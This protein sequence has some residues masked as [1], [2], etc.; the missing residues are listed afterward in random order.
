[1]LKRHKFETINELLR[2]LAVYKAGR[3]GIPLYAYLEITNRCNFRCVHCYC[4]LSSKRKEMTYSEVCLVLDQLADIGS[5]FLYIS[6]GEP[7]IRPDFWKILE[8]ARKKEFAIILNTN[9]SMITRDVAQRLADLIIFKVDMSIYGMSEYSYKTVTR[10]SGIF[11][12]IVRGLELLKEK[13]IRVFVKIVLMRDNFYQL[14]AFEKFLKKMGIEYK[15]NWVL[16]PRLDR[17]RSP[18]IHNLTKSQMEKFLR[19]HPEHHKPLWNSKPS[20]SVIMCGHASVPSFVC[21]NAYGEVMPCLLL[22][23][24]A[25]KHANIRERL[26]VE[27][28]KKDPLFLR[29][30]SFRWQ[31]MPQCLNCKALLYCAPCPADFVLAKGELTDTVPKTMCRRA[32]IRKRIH[33]EVKYDTTT[34]KISGKCQ[35]E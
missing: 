11:K 16:H 22:T 6:G 14:E 8:Y 18:L 1:M 24:L 19:S 7:F 5:L 32:W 12:K 33:E 15:I 13:G 23:T 9:G 27:I 35:I 17:C 10:V 2:Y 31:N 26:I 34:L 28:L 3:L 4:P 20:L 25:G 21:I 30:R 29:I